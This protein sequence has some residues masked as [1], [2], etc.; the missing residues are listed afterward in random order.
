MSTESSP[1]DA[2]QFE[3][4]KQQVRNM[5]AEVVELSKS[6]VDPAE[7]YEAFLT[8][9]VTALVAAGGVVWMV[10]D[11]GNLQPTYQINLQSVLAQDEE[12]FARHYRLLNKAFNEKSGMLVQPQSGA[13]GD[14]SAAN[15]TDWLLVLG[16]LASDRKGNAAGVIEIFQRPGSGPATQRGYLRFVLQLCEL[17]G[18]YLASQQ[19]RQLEERQKLWG[20]LEQ[21]TRSVHGSLEPIRTAFTVVNEGRRLIECD[22]VSVAIRRGSKYRIEAVSHQATVDRR[23]NIVALLSRLAT[24]VVATGDPMWYSGKTDD[25]A[26]QIEEAIHNYVDQS[27]AKVVGV[28]PLF[29]PSETKEDVADHKKT[30]T[31]EVIGALIVEQFGQSRLSDRMLQRVLVVK[32]H[33][34]SAIANALEHSG[35]FL[36]PLWRALGKLQWIVRARTLPKTI[37]IAVAVLIVILVLAFYP[38]DFYIEATG[39]LQPSIRKDVFVK[40]GGL[41][42]VVEPG[43]KH[44][45]FV[46]AGQPL[47]R[48]ENIDLDRELT[49]LE[50]ELAETRAQLQSINHELS[51]NKR[52][53][54]P[55]ELQK[56]RGQRMQLAKTEASLIKQIALLGGKRDQ[57]VIRSPIDGAIVTWDVR[58]LKGRTVRP[59]QIVMSIADS[60]ENWELELYVPGEDMGYIAQREKELKSTDHPD[61]PVAYILATDPEKEMVGKVKEIHNTVELHNKE[62]NTTL[63]LVD[64]NR[65]SID[66]NQLRMGTT[67]TAN[68]DC[69]KRSIGFVMFHDMIAWIQTKILFRF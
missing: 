1:T 30:K 19:L 11:E 25:M 33:A 3:A 46:K 64:I 5:V 57:L 27:Q 43:V 9:A 53:L 15:P 13:E 10:D 44:G 52:N 21:F 38:I 50:G 58:R 2:E 18:N 65:D 51:R 24:R 69:G 26:P 47:L 67:V 22:R 66:Q 39:Q 62:G 28:L 14:E 68:L 23:S 17:A 34:S 7:F 31:D 42:K 56:R 12:G 6:D 37:S 40:E 60:S 54:E 35:L 61:L 59:P 48:L 29:K 20:Q 16:P 32:D 63:I 36:M 41:I 4:T 49:R 8:R 55:G 45:A